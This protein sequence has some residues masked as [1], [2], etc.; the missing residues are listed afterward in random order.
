[1][2]ESAVLRPVNELLKNKATNWLFSGVLSKESSPRQV[3]S[4]TLVKEK[5]WQMHPRLPLIGSRGG[6]SHVGPLR[7]LQKSSSARRKRLS[8]QLGDFDRDVRLQPWGAFR[9]GKES[10]KKRGK[11]GGRRQRERLFFSD[12][13]WEEKLFCVLSTI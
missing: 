13:E 1:M 6:R 2:H 8:P 12:W 5:C 11:K 7:A 10:K 3:F 4:F 9:G